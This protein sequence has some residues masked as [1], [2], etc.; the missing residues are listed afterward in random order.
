MK[1]RPSTCP[2][3]LILVLL[4]AIG[5]G[6]ALVLAACGAEPPAVETR[7]ESPTGPVRPRFVT[8][9]VHEPAAFAR[10]SR[11]R[12]GV[13]HAYSDDLERCR[14]MKHYFEPPMN[15]DWAAVDLRAPFAGRIDE[16]ESE[17]AGDKIELVPDAAPDYRVVI[18][19]V[20]G[21]PQRIRE[22]ASVR[23]GEPL[24][25]HIGPQTM[26]DIAVWHRPS[27]GPRRL[28]S[29]FDVLTDEA[30]APFADVGVASR[31]AM[32]ITKAE[33]DAAPLRC[34]VDGRFTKDALPAGAPADWV[35]L[36]NAPPSTDSAPADRQHAPRRAH[37]RGDA[38]HPAHGQ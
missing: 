24:G 28:V 16:I 10:I 7:R 1:P 4:S 37:R 19:H 23:A 13:G 12:S 20:S 31:E 5:V 25:H 17:W 35:V 21:T 34:E 30:F 29:Y 33:R 2:P 36:G 8:V 14:S 15:V 11:F 6:P 32:M 18:F 38:Q 26:L 22:G 27:E 9:P 3:W